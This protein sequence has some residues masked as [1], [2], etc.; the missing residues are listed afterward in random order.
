VILINIRTAKHAAKA[1]SGH[2]PMC[3]IQQFLSTW[4]RCGRRWWR[5]CLPSS[6]LNT[7]FHWHV[8]STQGHCSLPLS[9]VVPEK[10]LHVSA[11]EASA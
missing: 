2:Q 7:V 11:F 6:L 3:K 8:Q 10:R 1:G 5:L 9:M 4:V